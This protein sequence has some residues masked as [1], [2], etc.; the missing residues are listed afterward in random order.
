MKTKYILHLLLLGFVI[1]SCTKSDKDPLANLDPGTYDSTWWNR[2][3][4]RLIQT[5]LPE[6]QADMDMDEYV[7]TILD[8]SANTVLL[9]V[10][11]IVANY[12]TKLP[13]H[14]KNPYTKEDLVDGL[15]E[16]LHSH[17]I[18]VLGRF[19]FS[20]VNETIAVNKP[21]W[22]YIGTSGKTVNYNGQVHTCINGAYQQEYSFEILREAITSY[23]LDGIFFNMIGYTTT[24]YDGT[25]HGICQCNSC[26]KR[27]L[28]STGF[29]LP[30]NP[31]MSDPVY[32]S[33]RAFQRST[34][35]EL[36]GRIR[37]HIK[38]LNP[39]III[40]TYTDAGVDLIT[41]EAAT[42]L[43]DG[44]DWNYFSTGN[45]KPTLGSYKD[46][47]PS[48]LVMYFQAIGY[49]H[50]GPPPNLARVWFEENM[51]HGA[52]A[53][54]VIIGTM[55]NHE[56]RIFFPV[57]KELMGFHKKN[58]KLFTNVQ[59]AGN[60]A[61]IRGS[62]AEY[63]GLI[64]LLTEEH[65]IYEVLEPSAIGSSRASRNL[66]DYDVVIIGDLSNMEDGQVQIIDE[67]VSNGGKL[68]TTGITSVND[69]LGGIRN[70]LG[71]KSL[72]VPGKFIIL[73][74]EESTYLKVSEADKEAIGKEEFREFDLMMMYSR[75]INCQ[76]VDGAQGYFRLVP[77]TMFGPPEKIYYTKENITDIPGMIVNSHGKGKS[78]FIPWQLGAQYNFK[79]NYAHR[80]L[81]MASLRNLLDF[82][83][84]IETD[85][86]PLIEMTH[87][88]SRNGAFEWIGM[89]NHSGQLGSSFRD[90]VPIFNTRIRFRP[91]KPVRQ[92]SLMRTGK[93]ITFTQEDGWVECIVPEVRD[94]EMVLYTY[95]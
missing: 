1:S 83:T 84:S 12:P 14:F 27:F 77:H 5:N 40:N 86:S 49:R 60:I 46:I 29:K 91:A 74:Q 78:V 95:N 50:I 92:I 51:L 73:P 6:I 82:E 21:E 53:T 4:I 33:Y 63:Q 89:I 35:N 41:T 59:S 76:P 10:G 75:F 26:K 45:L 31:D 68:L 56:D 38:T 71:L 81:F 15:L 65:I 48:N 30:V 87:M 9:N 34:S 36:F 32:R 44:Y 67:Y 94:F 20:K 70:E 7:Q 64:K 54:Y 24:D 25:Y 80:A 22:L 47:T 72:G 85:A 69:A 39:K 16:R 62:Y 2:A 52:P 93:Q 79:G 28:D 88:V 66:E 11:G 58:E 61:L 3:P 42:S 17:G 19:D 57:M 43:R 90:P 55:P 13:Y 23:P 8:A 37:D 18:K